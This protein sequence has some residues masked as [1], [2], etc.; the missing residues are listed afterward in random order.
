MR[1]KSI[2]YVEDDEHDQW[3]LQ[4]A[5]RAEGTTELLY[6]VR[7]GDEA[8]GWLDGGGDYEDRTKY[9][10]PHLVLLDIRLQKV[11]GFEVL[12][13][14]RAKPAFSTLPI[15]MFSSSK[16]DRDVAES[17]RLRANLFLVKPAGLDEFR[18]I[19]VFLITWV[20]HGQAPP[21]DETLWHPLPRGNENARLPGAGDPPV[22]ASP[23]AG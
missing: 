12:R 14:A 16:Q 11:H 1:A 5:F 9:P 6:M 18:H 23:L 2:L 4:R 17:Y 21:T 20:R 13:W 7:D 22:G 8:M 19:A 3:L 10:V 15:I